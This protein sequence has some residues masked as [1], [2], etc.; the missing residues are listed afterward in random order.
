[1]EN[2]LDQKIPYGIKDHCHSRGHKVIEYSLLRPPHSYH[3]LHAVCWIMFQT[4]AA[5]NMHHMIAGI[6]NGPCGSAGV[7][8]CCRQCG[9]AFVHILPANWHKFKQHIA[10]FRRCSH[11]MQMEHTQAFHNT[12][13]G[14][15]CVFQLCKPS[16]EAIR[17]KL[18]FR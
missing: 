5:A 10:S 2:S 11:F 4:H 6:V 8:I 18:G 12:N 15:L 16:S 1:M 13:E 9:E 3:L 14:R 17:Q 7:S